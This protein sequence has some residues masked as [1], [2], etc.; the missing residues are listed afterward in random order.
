MMNLKLT[1]IVLTI[2]QTPGPFFARE[3]FVD[4]LQPFS[5]FGKIFVFLLILYALLK[6]LNIL[7]SILSAVNVSP[8]GGSDAQ[9]LVTTSHPAIASCGYCKARF[10]RNRVTAS[11]SCPNCGGEVE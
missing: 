6:G 9:S 2:L 10:T 7:M 3:S 11:G 5:I 1:I 8:A 4:L